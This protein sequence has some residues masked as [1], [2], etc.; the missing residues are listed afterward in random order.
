MSRILTRQR[1]EEGMFLEEETR[2]YEGSEV[3]KKCSV[4]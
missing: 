4:E 1:I 2:Q 3:E